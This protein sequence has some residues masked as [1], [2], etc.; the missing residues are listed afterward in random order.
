MLEAQKPE[1]SSS[2]HGDIPA[3]IYQAIS[4]IIEDVK[5]KHA[6]LSAR[7][8]RASLTRSRSGGLTS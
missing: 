7:L 8:D 6:A 2:F 1:A 5:I 4:I 3:E